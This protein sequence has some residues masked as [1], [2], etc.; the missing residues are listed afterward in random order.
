MEF[1]GVLDYA[2]NLKYIKSFIKLA[3][4]AILIVVLFYKIDIKA[5]EQSMLKVGLW[6]FIF[7]SFYYIT[8]HIIG[9]IRWRYVIKSLSKDIKAIE[10]VK[11]Y[12]LGTFSNLFLPGIVGG[13][14][15][16][17]FVVSKKLPLQN[18]ISSVFLDRY[19]G[20]QVLLLIA[21]F[22]VLIFA[23]F[24]SLKLILLVVGV[25]IVILLPVY[26]LKLKVFRRFQKIR[27][28]HDDIWA[29]LRNKYLLP[30]SVLSLLIQ[31]IVISIY[32]VTANILCFHLDYV[33]FFAF[34]PIINFASSLPISFNGIGVREFCFVYFF[35]LVGLSKIKALTLS[36]EV[37]FIVIFS[38][39]VEGGLYYVLS[40]KSLE[41]FN[42]GK[43]FSKS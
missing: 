3:V 35:G 17:V 21:L 38:S 36:L 7:L 15:V 10:L 4:S 24:F 37:F 2:S 22:D 11:A 41:R 5:L 18:S 43:L 42:L 31:L 16:K 23:R 13:D 28:F 20:L 8:T 32:I 39:L 9:S 25:N 26:L 19:N 33:Y 12:F 34:I 14:A 40:L 1:K 29:F 27:G 6:Q 30:A